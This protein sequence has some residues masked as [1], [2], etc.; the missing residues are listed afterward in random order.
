[1]VA[2]C[3]KCPSMEQPPWLSTE[4]RPW[5]LSGSAKLRHL[6]STSFSGGILGDEQ[7]L[8]KSLTVLTTI[9]AEIQA[10]GARPYHGF[11]LIITTKSCVPQWMDEVK[12]HLGPVSLNNPSSTVSAPADVSL[13]RPSPSG[14]SFS[15]TLLPQQTSYLKDAI[16]LSSAHTSSLKAASV[17]SSRTASSTT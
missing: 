17:R 1:M 16:T 2:R 11:N 6:A 13:L 5:Q 9:M 4:P 10:G 7:G 12:F 8:G 15:T 3:P 14:P